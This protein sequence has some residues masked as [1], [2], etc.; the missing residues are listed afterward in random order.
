[1]ARLNLVLVPAH[2][3]GNCLYKATCDWVFNRWQ[4]HAD[5]R[6]AVTN[7]LAL[8]WQDVALRPLFYQESTGEPLNNA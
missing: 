3:D 6:N 7:F 4:L 5:L 2:T 8:H 1:M